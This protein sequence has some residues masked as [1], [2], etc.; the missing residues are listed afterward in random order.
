MGLRDWLEERFTT[1][2]SIEG[3]ARFSCTASPIEL[4]TMEDEIYEAVAAGQVP[5]ASD[6][7]FVRD[8]RR[9]DL[10]LLKEERLDAA[11]ANG[12]A[13]QAGRKEPEPTVE[14]DHEIDAP[15]WDADVDDEHRRHAGMGI[16]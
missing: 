7:D 9:Y 4:G 6:G 15:S 2:R 11:Q 5:L 1:R 16:G 13:L 8:G 12:T 14:P 10:G 3:A